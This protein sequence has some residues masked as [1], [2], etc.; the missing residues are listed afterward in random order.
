LNDSPSFPSI[1]PGE[2]PWTDIRTWAW[3]NSPLI[4][5]PGVP[6][7]TQPAS[8]VAF[9]SGWGAE[10]VLLFWAN[11]RAAL[12]PHTRPITSFIG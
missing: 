2:K 4:G 8:A 7:G 5:E 6:G 10:A 3:K 12:L 1:T 11:A 9:A